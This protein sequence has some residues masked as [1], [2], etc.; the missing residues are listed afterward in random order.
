MRRYK[1]RRE[2]IRRVGEVGRDLKKV[3]NG[4]ERLEESYKNRELRYVER[5]EE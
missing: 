5:R 3:E 1:E 4:N 2:K